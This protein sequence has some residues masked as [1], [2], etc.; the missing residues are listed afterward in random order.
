MGKLS[1]T[2]VRA[3]A[4][5]AQGTV[6]TAYFYQEDGTPGTS[7]G[8]HVVETAAG[9]ARN[10]L[11]GWMGLSPAIFRSLHQAGYIALVTQVRYPDG[12]IAYHYTL[13]AAGRARLESEAA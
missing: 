1:A 11:C 10:Q 7:D 8:W 6:L 4:H 2:A 13:S 9:R 5:L 12:W 3:L